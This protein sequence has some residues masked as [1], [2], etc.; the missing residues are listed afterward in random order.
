MSRAAIV[1]LLHAGYSDKAI[2]RQVHTHRNKV[3]DLR[4]ELGL[5]VHQP[6]PTPS[7]AEDLFWR[8]AQPTPDGHLLWPGTARTVRTGHEGARRSVGQIAFR[9][10][11][12]RDAVGYVTAG[13]EVAGCI[14]PNHVEDQPMRQ[15]YAA[16]FG[17]IEATA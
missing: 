1:E 13:C 12:H 6:G 16:I 2:A 14:H 15:Q 3:R 9:I 7:G 17:D 4:H 5:P 11:H 10:R 8:Q